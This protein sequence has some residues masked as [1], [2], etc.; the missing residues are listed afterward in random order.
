MIIF[1]KG[2]KIGARTVKTV[3][4]ASLAIFIADLLGLEYATAA[5]VIAILSVTNTKKSTFKSGKNRLLNFLFAMLLSTILFNLL[6][7]HVLIFSLFLLVFIPCSAAWGMSEAISPNAVLVTHLLVAPQITTSL[8]LNEFLLNFIAISLAFIVN[9]KMPNFQDELTAREKRVEHHFRDL[10]KRLSFIM[11]K[12]IEQTHFLHKV[13]DLEGYI[14]DSLVIARRHMDNK[15]SGNT[16]GSYDY[17]TMRAT[18][19]ELFREI[20][21]IL[22]QIDMTGQDQQFQSLE[23]LFKAISDTYAR[24]NNGKALMVQTEEILTHYRSSE[25]PKTREEFEVRARLFQILQLI[26]TF[27]QIKHDYVIESRA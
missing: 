24:D 25:L 22:I 7:H 23:Q 4:A 13:E 21:E 16:S 9:W 5:G 27:I 2:F 11:D 6:G 19:V 26:Q 8:L 1:P 15:L 14:L 20:T 12:K 17:L 10:F 18:Q 3:I